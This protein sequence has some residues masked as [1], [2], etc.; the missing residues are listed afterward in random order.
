MLIDYSCPGCR[1][2][3]DPRRIPDEKKFFCPHCGKPMHIRRA[4][5]TGW[6]GHYSTPE[7]QR[8]L[9]QWFE[10]LMSKPWTP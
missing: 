2:W 3:I 7:Q 8:A 5:R 4:V 1:K 9:H 10:N 6:V